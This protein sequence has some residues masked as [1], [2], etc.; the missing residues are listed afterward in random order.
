MQAELNRRESRIVSENAAGIAADE[1]TFAQHRNR[2][3]ES[4]L[5]RLSWLVRRLDQAAAKKG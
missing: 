2:E 5:P 4:F 1:R 3:A